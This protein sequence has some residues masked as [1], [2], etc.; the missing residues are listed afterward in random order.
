MGNRKRI[1]DPLL[2]FGWAGYVCAAILLA[3]IAALVAGVDLRY[4]LMRLIN[5]TLGT[6]TMMDFVRSPLFFL[7]VSLFDPFVSISTGVLGLAAFRIAPYRI[8][9]LFQAA[10][11]LLC[12]G[13][14]LVLVFFIYNEIPFERAL[15]RAFGPSYVIEFYTVKIFLIEIVGTLLIGLVVYKLTRSRLVGALWALA[16]ALQC[17]AATLS[18]RVMISNT[19]IPDFLILFHGYDHY[20]YTLFSLAFDILTMGSLLLWAI[21]ERRKI[22]PAQMCSSCGYDL[23]GLA[24]AAPCPECAHA[25]TGVVEPNEPRNTP[26]P[27]GG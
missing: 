10:V 21:L 13:W 16:V 6:D 11:F 1:K 4:E 15:K 14:C 20:R 8:H 17:I 25:Q 23:A 12:A 19:P 9:P 18:V 26:T 5:A 3:L 7:S 24:G 22:V 2:G 27:E